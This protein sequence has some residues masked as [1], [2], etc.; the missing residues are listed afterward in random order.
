MIAYRVIVRRYK[1]GITLLTIDELLEILKVDNQIEIIQKKEHRNIN[2]QHL[3]FNDERPPVVGQKSYF[4]HG[5]VYVGKH[6]RYSGMPEHR[7]DFVEINYML[8]GSSVHHVDGETIEL[9]QSEILLMDKDTIQSIDLLNED[10]ILINILIK[11]ETISTSML[12]EMVRNDSLV[13]KF[14]M[15]DTL[16][17]N[18]TTKHFM[19]FLTNKSDDAVEDVERII[20]E[21]FNKKIQY[22][23]KIDSL[24]EL[25]L[26]DLARFC[27]NGNKMEKPESDLLISVLKYIDTFYM[28][29]S[30]ADLGHKTGYNAKYL[31]R[32][33]KS[34]TRKSFKEL[35]SLKRYQVAINLLKTTD[36]TVTELAYVLGFETPAAVYK[37]F[38]KFSDTP[39]NKN[40]YNSSKT[41]SRYK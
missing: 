18:Q 30:L 28:T 4:R 8:S 41:P 37:M 1:M 16:L 38:S 29:A 26:I 36:I 23:L 35:V 5:N 10:D 14:M 3:L 17:A 7:H 9:H 15:E 2:D 27:D 39:P 33:L 21:F 6:N 19:H 34:D 32:K 25:C 31:S 22:N 40:R 13:G 24:L 11:K 20:T 12:S